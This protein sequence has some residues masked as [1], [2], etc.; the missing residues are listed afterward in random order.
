MMIVGFLWTQKQTPPMRDQLP[1][2][3]PEASARRDSGLS[4]RAEDHL[5]CPKQ[6]RVPAHPAH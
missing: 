3:G 2:R 5:G 1:K 4:A 6:A